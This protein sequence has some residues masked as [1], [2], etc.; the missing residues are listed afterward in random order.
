ML[1]GVPYDMQKLK[2]AQPTIIGTVTCCLTPD[3]RL[4]AALYR[5][6][7]GSGDVQVIPRLC[8]EFGGEK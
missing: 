7:F 6:P 3:G 4:T 2:R 5:R 1:F 8:P